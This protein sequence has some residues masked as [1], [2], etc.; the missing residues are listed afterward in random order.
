VHPDLWGLMEYYI[1]LPPDFCQVRVAKWW[2]W[3]LDQYFVS[4]TYLEWQ[5]GN[6]KKE[7][8]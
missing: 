2:K 4:N 3:T 5:G 6:P 1:H 8:L 7:G